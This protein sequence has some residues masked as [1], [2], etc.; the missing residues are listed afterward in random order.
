MTNFMSIINKIT[1]LTS[2]IEANYPELYHFLDEDPITIPNESHPNMDK[3]TFIAYLDSL[4]QLLKHHLETHK[5]Q[6]KHP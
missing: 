1:Q 6:I 2:N 4:K 5:T 3:T